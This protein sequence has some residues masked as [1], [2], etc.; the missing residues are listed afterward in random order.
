MFRR[1]SRVSAAIDSRD[2]LLLLGLGLFAAGLW[3]IWAPIAL[4][5]LGLIFVAA[6]VGGEAR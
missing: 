5:A 3:L 1:R 6:A 2:I 4:V